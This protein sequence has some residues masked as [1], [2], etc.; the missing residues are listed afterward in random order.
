MFDSKLES[1]FL[2]LLHYASGDFMQQIQN[3]LWTSCNGVSWIAMFYLILG[4][5]DLGLIIYFYTK[6]S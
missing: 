4:S 2:I 6:K 5:D 1:S 3:G